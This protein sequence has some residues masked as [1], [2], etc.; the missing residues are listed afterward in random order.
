MRY[1]CTDG[2]QFDTDGDGAGDRVSLDIR[3]QWDEV[4][5]PWVPL[6]PCVITHCI[7][8]PDRPEDTNLRELTSSWTPINTR[9]EYD[10]GG[11]QEYGRYTGF[12][13]TDRSKSTFDILCKPDGLYD[14][15]DE[16]GNWPTCLQD[17]TC[18]LPPEIPSHDDYSLPSDDGHVIYQSLIYPTLTDNSAT[19]NSTVK[20]ID[21]PRNYMTNLTYYCGAARQF[22]TPDGSH[23]ESMSATCQWDTT[24]SGVTTLPPCDWVACLEP[25]KPPSWTNL[26]FIN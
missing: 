4:W 19:V 8:P 24:W 13:Q 6:P 22:L 1:R 18:P 16:R 12:W 17:I 26:R 3:C 15:V 10:C 2:S 25:P 9:K 23:V 5:T 21:I 11:L 20:N 14:F 7:S